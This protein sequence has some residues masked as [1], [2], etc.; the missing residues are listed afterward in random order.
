MV[1]QAR[2]GYPQL[3]ETRLRMAASLQHRPE[4]EPGHALQ[5]ATAKG[6]GPSQTDDPPTPSPAAR[7]ASRRPRSPFAPAIAKEMSA[8]ATSAVAIASA[9]A[10]GVP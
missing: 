7:R 8:V 4:H 6:Q 2:R 1:A 5:A 10:I 3:G 9:T